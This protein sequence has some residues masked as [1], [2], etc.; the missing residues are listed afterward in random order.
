LVLLKGPAGIL[1]AALTPL[2]D[3]VIE[4][5]ALG[6]PAD[7]RAFVWRHYI[8]PD[9][10]QA[11]AGIMSAANAVSELFRQLDLRSPHAGPLLQAVVRLPGKLRGAGA[12]G[13]GHQQPMPDY[14]IQVLNNAARL[15]GDTVAS[16]WEELPLT[17]RYDAARSAVRPRGRAG[18]T[19]ADLAGQGDPVAV[20]AAADSELGRLLTISPVDYNQ[21]TLSDSG[22]VTDHYE[23]NRSPVGVL[24]THPQETS[25]WL[26]ANI[27]IP[28]IAGL[29][30]P[31]A[32]ELPAGKEL[33]LLRAITDTTTENEAR[34]TDAH[35]LTAPGPGPK[36]APG[37]EGEPAAERDTATVAVALAAHL[38]HCRLAHEERLTLLASLGT[39]GP[40][41]GLS[42]ILGAA[43]L[44]HRQ[45][46]IRPF[47]GD[48]RPGLRQFAAEISQSLRTLQ[49]ALPARQ[50]MR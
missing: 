35:N 40:P 50:A 26:A 11:M 43:G 34:P 30:L 23:E 44:A 13:L 15:I 42:R 12:R 49:N 45:D 16:R 10:P 25:D 4:E 37:S 21:Y 32:D 7:A 31:V 36:L 18:S 2:L 38:G 8:L 47:L 48:P 5:H 28:R 19:L 17:A 29:A 27:G 6:T 22:R 3:V 33:A 9:D 41:G 20:A 24:E 39:S 1:L 14:G 46:V